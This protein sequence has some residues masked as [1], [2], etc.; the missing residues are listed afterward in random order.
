MNNKLLKAA[1]I[2]VCVAM[3]CSLTACSK[4]GT[5]VGDA[6]S[7][8]PV[9]I[10]ADGSV[11][12]AARGVYLEE[13]LSESYD[14]SS[15]TAITLNGDSAALSGLG[16]SVSDSVVTISNAGVYVVSGSLTNGQIVID[17]DKN[18]NVRLVLNGADIYCESSAPIYA[19]KCEKLTVTLADSSENTLTGG[20]SYTFADGGDEPDGALF[21]KG[22]L[23][24]N[25]SGA[26]SVTANCL[27]GIVSKDTL[28]ITGGNI[29][30]TAADDA[31]RGKDFVSI[32]DGSFTLTS[33]GD[34]IKS[35]NTDDASLGTVII[36]GGSFNIISEGDGIQAETSLT[37]TD[38]DFEITTGGGSIIT[39]ARS[40]GSFA[41]G[42]GSGQRPGLTTNAAS[43]TE[44]P[45]LPEGEAGFTPP[46]GTQ[47]TPPEMPQGGMGGRGQMPQDGGMPQRGERPDM[48]LTQGGGTAQ[49]DSSTAAA[50]TGDSI[51]TKGLKAGTTL[52]IT[53]GSFTLNCLDDAIHSNGDV[54]VSGGDFSITTDDDGVHADDTLTI[55]GSTI[56]ITR[57]YEGLEGTEVIINGGEIALTAFDDGVNSAGGSDGKTSADSFIGH[58][59]GSSDCNITVTGGKLYVN[60]YGDGL[61]ANGSI[62]QSGGAI[63]V[64][65][66]QNGGNGALDYDGSYDISGGTLISAGSSGMAQNTSSSSSQP[67]LAVT[68][69]ESKAAGSVINL[70][71]ASGQL[72]VSY[73]PEK[74]YQHFV[75]SSSELKAGE[76]YTLYAGEAGSESR[77]SG[78]ADAVSDLG[79][80]LCTVTLSTES[81]L[82]FISDDGSERQGG[83][84]R[85]MRR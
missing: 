41:G 65:G 51:S 68:F 55:D 60:A 46:D 59:G 25:G 8:P 35:T 26:L 54:T 17:A 12:S 40:D 71:D 57:S 23:V 78:V 1:A 20:E 43:R 32:L 56:D 7:V 61:D 53:G 19:K 15:A 73:S 37:I 6:P 10:E 83:G 14:S 84:M 33:G 79:E 29:T 13:D 28:V 81:S 3:I 66:P 64:S 24:I 52:E 42:F 50:A 82:T 76:S 67:A 49:R 62:V 30:V 5:D 44:P 75:F 22:D 69:T 80:H 72:I 31:I 2:A 70:T 39:E 47:G 34:A 27:D 48:S 4:G 11:A 63:V 58:M 16:A 38:G 85:G 45:A 21:S 74:T 36:D 77:T 18:D 9:Q